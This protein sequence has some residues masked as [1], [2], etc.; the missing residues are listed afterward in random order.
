MAKSRGR[1]T[2]PKLGF[3]LD[4]SIVMA[5]S[6]EDE[7]NHYAD[8]TAYLEL[9]IRM[10]LPLATIDGKLKAATLAAGAAFFQPA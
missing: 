8:A 5:W 6:F 10:G 1:A 2:R 7:S 3:V 9:A 4:N